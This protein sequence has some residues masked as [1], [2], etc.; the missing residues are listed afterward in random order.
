MKKIK[1]A[2]LECKKLETEIYDDTFNFR[3]NKINHEFSQTLVIPKH[4]C[5][6]F[7]LEENQYPLDPGL[8]R[9]INDLKNKGI[10]N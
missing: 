8:E 10:R 7:L 5:R 2:I 3:L 9:L 4:L 6:Y 1:A